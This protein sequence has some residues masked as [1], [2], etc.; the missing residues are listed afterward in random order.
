MRK[1]LEKVVDRFDLEGLDRVRIVRGC[2]N[3][4]RWIAERTKDTEPIVAR[5]LHIEKNQIRLRTLN[6]LD[7]CRTVFGFSDDFDIG[8]R[9][10]KALRPIPRELLV[11][12]EHQPHRSQ[13]NTKWRQ[14]LFARRELAPKGRRPL[15]DPHPPMGYHG[16]CPWT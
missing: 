15:L 14:R 11:V 8:E 16:F 3:H 12:N 7:C 6:D 5:H 1:G 2:K 9:R 10:E 13:P 4:L